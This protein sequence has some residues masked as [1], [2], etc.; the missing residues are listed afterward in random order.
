MYISQEIQ[1]QVRVD[2]LIAMYGADHASAAYLLCDR[3]DPSTVAYQIVGADL[4][5]TT[6]T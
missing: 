4:S 1:P 2:Q 3:H 5:V 6:I